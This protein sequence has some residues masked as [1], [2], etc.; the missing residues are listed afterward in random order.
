MR[1]DWRRKDKAVVA[2][3]GGNEQF[4]EH[5]L[6]GRRMHFVSVEAWWFRAKGMGLSRTG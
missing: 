4:L 2:C 3:A 5:S 6:G 1:E